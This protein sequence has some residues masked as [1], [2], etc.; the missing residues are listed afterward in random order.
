MILCSKSYP[1]CIK[2]PKTRW[3]LC[4][5][6]PG[7][8]ANDIQTSRSHGPKMTLYRVNEFVVFMVIDM[9][10]YHPGWAAPLMF[11]SSLLKGMIIG[12]ICFNFYSVGVVQHVNKKFNWFLPKRHPSI[13]KQ[14]KDNGCSNSPVSQNAPP[15]GCACQLHRRRQN[16]Y[17]HCWFHMQRHF[18]W[19]NKVNQVLCKWLF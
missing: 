13:T 15:C 14:N 8:W 5:C 16:H 19:L 11:A 7:R 6:I 17:K 9:V 10:Q 1:K 18:K 4:I 3:R 2:L 12:N